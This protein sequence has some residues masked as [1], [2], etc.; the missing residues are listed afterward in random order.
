MDISL[1]SHSP[2]NAGPQSGLVPGPGPDRERRWMVYV[3][4]DVKISRGSTLLTQ[5]SV[6]FVLRFW[7][8]SPLQEP[9]L[10]YAL[11][12]TRPPRFTFLS[13]ARG[14]PARSALKRDI[15]SAAEDRAPSL[16]KNLRFMCCY[17]CFQHRQRT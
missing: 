1:D 5:I 4:Y 9:F 7:S 16:Q 3:A 17:L 10:K 2:L 6:Q 8:G 14:S 11:A 15:C 13:E 12:R